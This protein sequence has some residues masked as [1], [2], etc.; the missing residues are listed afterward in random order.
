MWVYAA[1]ASARRPRSGRL[2]MHLSHEMH[3]LP[4]LYLPNN[5]PI[6]GQSCSETPIRWQGP[7]VLMDTVKDEDTVHETQLTMDTSEAKISPWL[8]RKADIIRRCI[9]F[10]PRSQCVCSPAFGSLATQMPPYGVVSEQDYIYAF[11]PTWVKERKASRLC[12][13]MRTCSMDRTAHQVTG[14]YKNS[15]C[16]WQVRSGAG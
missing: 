1:G 11:S 6:W 4:H 10:H 3:L 14:W 16:N 7:R 13:V 8:H 2:G 12:Q 9:S 5:V 15:S